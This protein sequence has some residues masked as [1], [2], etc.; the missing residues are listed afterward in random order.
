MVQK[1]DDRITV[2]IPDQNNKIKYWQKFEEARTPKYRD[3]FLGE[4][5]WIA[6]AMRLLHSYSNLL[7]L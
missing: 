1:Y 5:T 3:F 4:K 2:I 7:I 6:S